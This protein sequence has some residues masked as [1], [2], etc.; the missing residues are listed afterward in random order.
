MQAFLFD[1]SRRSISQFTRVRNLALE[2]FTEHFAR[3]PI[4]SG[5]A[6]MI[7]NIGV[8]KLWQGAVRISPGIAVAN[9]LFR[10]QPDIID[11]LDARPGNRLR[12]G[13]DDVLDLLIDD[14]ANDQLVQ[15]GFMCI[16]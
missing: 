8:E 11:A 10:L 3:A 5:Y 1:P 16:R 15:F 12:G 2:N 13:G 4:L 14:L 7:I 9:E 6:G